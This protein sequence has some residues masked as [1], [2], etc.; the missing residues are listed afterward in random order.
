ALKMREA[1][2]GLLKTALNDPTQ[3]GAVLALAALPD[4]RA[5]PVY[6]GALRDRSAEVRRAGEIALLTIRD[7]VKADLEQAARS[8]R[9]EGPSALSLE[10]VLTRFKPVTNWRVIGPFPRTTAA[11]FVGEPSIDFARTHTGAEGRI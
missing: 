3:T 11:L 6:L 7:S 5:L 4:P 9:F 1:V 8:G 2:P 10:H